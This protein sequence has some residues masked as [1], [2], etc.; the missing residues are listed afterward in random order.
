MSNKTGNVRE[1]LRQYTKLLE[2][3][4]DCD[5]SSSVLEEKINN[6]AKYVPCRSLEK[7]SQRITE[8][9]SQTNKKSHE[10]EISNVKSIVI[11]ALSI[12]CFVTLTTFVLV[13]ICI[14]QQNNSGAIITSVFGGVIDSILSVL[15]AFFHSTLKSKKAYFDA[16]NDTLKLNK[17]LMLV[18]YVSEERKKDEVIANIIDKYFE[19]NKLL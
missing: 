18:D 11:F 8:M 9:N 16:E 13:S 5:K 2:D 4:L 1:F 3:P 17:V 12:I 7:Y 6:T 19:S 15:T 14:F 10:D